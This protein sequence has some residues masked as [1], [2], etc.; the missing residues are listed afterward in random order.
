MTIEVE[1]V[2]L[3]SDLTFEAVVRS[4]ES[5]TGSVEGPDYRQAV[6]AADT[7]E[8]FEEIIHKQEGTSGFMPRR[9]DEEVRRRSRE[10]KNV[11]NR[12][13]AYRANHAAA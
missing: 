4:F 5:A 2:E 12:E 6:A 8:E 9:L 1:Y 3:V 7:K 13:P 10:S 11:H